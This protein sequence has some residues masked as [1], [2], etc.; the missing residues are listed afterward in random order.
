M[1][2]TIFT[3]LPFIVQ[4]ITIGP[5][6]CRIHP[7]EPR[8]RRPFDMV[9]RWIARNGQRFRISTVAGIQYVDRH[10]TCSRQF[11]SWHEIG[12]A[13]SVTG[14]MHRLC[15]HY[16]LRIRS[17]VATEWRTHIRSES[18]RS[19][20]R[21]VENSAS[22]LRLD[23]NRTECALGRLDSTWLGRGGRHWFLLR[24]LPEIL[25][26]VGRWT[27]S[28]SIQ[29]PLQ[30][31][32]EVYQPGTVADG[33][34]YASAACKITQLYGCFV[35]F[36]ARITSAFRRFETGRSDARNAVSSDANAHILARGI[37]FWFSG[38]W[39]SAVIWN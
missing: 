38:E 35:G 2:F 11:A 28:G 27:L 9:S 5:R 4:W 16:A 15:W 20:G 10:P 36:L 25:R 18:T 17:T 24:V 23:G 6:A 39:N 8:E 12:R 30:C 21:I 19:H 29:S 14:N 32:D 31:R 33:R 3:F 7:E 13:E 34:P 37:H 26:F 22:W 1:F